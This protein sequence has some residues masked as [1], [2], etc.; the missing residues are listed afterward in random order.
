MEFIK[1]H[2]EKIIMSAVLLCLLGAAVWLP[3]MI[4]DARE[5]IN[6]RAGAEPPVRPWKAVDFSV[7]SNALAA[8]Q[9]PF[10]V[11]LAGGIPPEYHNLFNPVTWKMTTT[12]ASPGA[13]AQPIYIKIYKE[14]PEALVVKEIRPLYLTVAF[15]RV[16]GAG[17]YFYFQKQSGK[18][19]PLYLHVKDIAKV[20]G[21]PVFTLLGIKGAP[22]NPTEFQVQM[23]DTQ[24]IVTVT[25]QLPFQKIDGYTADLSYPPDPN[26]VLKNKRVGDTFTLAGETYKV[27]AISK[28]DVRVQATSNDKQ[29]TINWSGT[30]AP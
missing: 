26:L 11:Q 19:N 25:P 18:K 28:N 5:Q 13:P 1:R 20:S 8:L 4:S 9:T 2:Y 15:D 22:E 29:T 3:K 24:E 7:Q 16:A 30:P 27:V 14:G 17:Y 6:Q 23:L 21:Q 10:S 12:N